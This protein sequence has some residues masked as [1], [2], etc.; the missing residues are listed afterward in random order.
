MHLGTLQ[1]HRRAILRG[2]FRRSRW[3]GRFRVAPFCRL[4]RLQRL[5]LLPWGLPDHRGHL[6][7]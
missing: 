5:P 4:C 7:I 2:Q 6:S 1:T 3:V